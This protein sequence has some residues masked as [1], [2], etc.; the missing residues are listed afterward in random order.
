[1]ITERLQCSRCGAFSWEVLVDEHS[2]WR[3]ADKWLAA[4]WDS[5]GDALYC[6]KCVE[7]W[8]ERNGNDRQLW[9]EDHTRI[10]IYEQFLDVLIAE[11]RRE[12][13]KRQR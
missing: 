5:F 9:G 10:K 1:M 3:V 4:G 8:E 13:E 6:P 2:Y 11:L 12:R 7:T